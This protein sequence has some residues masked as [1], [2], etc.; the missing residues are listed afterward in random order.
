MQVCASGNLEL[1]EY[2]LKHGA[3]PTLQDEDG[4]LQ[5]AQKSQLDAAVRIG[6][7]GFPVMFVIPEKDGGSLDERDGINVLNMLCEY[8]KRAAANKIRRRISVCKGLYGR[9]WAN[10]TRRGPY[11]VLFLVPKYGNVLYM[12]C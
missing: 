10:L 1:A 7:L 8:Y 11:R 6:P 9:A 12:F 5:E 2:L 3:A 4:E